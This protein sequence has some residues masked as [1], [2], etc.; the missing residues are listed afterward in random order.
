M[1]RR[2]P[3]DRQHVV[4]PERLLQTQRQTSHRGPKEGEVQPTGRRPFDSPG[5]VQQLEE[6]QILERLVLR[7]LR[8]NSDAKEGT[9]RAKTAAGHHGQAQVGCG[10]S[11]EEHRE[12]AEDRVFRI[13]PERGEERPP[14]GL[15]D[16]GRQS[17]GVHPPLERPL[18]PTTG[19]V[20]I[21]ASV[22]Y[23][24]FDNC[25]AAG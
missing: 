21:D 10:V 25:H 8:A 16:S 15:P 6:Q 2:N 1:L 13:F 24:T 3:D 14:R 22:G 17:G 5:G 20:S 18:Q 11:R 4:G 23:A 19:V 7:E 9:R 12:G